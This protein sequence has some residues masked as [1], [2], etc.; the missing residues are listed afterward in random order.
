MIDLDE[1]AHAIRAMQRHQPLYRVIRDEL[2]RRGNWTT[3]RRGRSFQKGQD[4][5]REGITGKDSQ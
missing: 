2:K 5:R 4:D 1:L 3:K